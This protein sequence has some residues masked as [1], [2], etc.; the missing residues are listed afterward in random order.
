VRRRLVVEQRDVI[1]IVGAGPAGLAVAGS[2]AQRGLQAT[3]I[4][5]ADD[6][7]AS[8]RG[9]DERLRLH[10]VKEESA[11][12]GMPFPADWPRYVP[13]ERMVDYL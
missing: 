12:P 13:R 2:L 3:R 9:H 11:L 8:W 1:L 6:I 10:T 5:K 4:E 7:G